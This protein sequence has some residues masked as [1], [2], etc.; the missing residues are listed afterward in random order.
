MNIQ[1]TE[2]EL[3][4]FRP[5]PFYFVTTTDK[6]EL[7]FESVYASL[8]RLKEEGFG[9]IVLFNKPPHGFDAE[10]YLSDAWFEMVRNFAEVSKKLELDLW[11]NDG[12][13][14]PP[15][16]VGGRICKEKYPHLAQKRLK[17]VNDQV[18]DEEVDWGFPAFE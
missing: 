2:K 9:G 11:I 6:N 16:S 13:D 12:F 1:P 7:S 4:K 3:Q 8:E 15:G 17:L 10:L 14:F 18:V 5:K